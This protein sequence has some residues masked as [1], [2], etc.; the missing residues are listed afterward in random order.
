MAI[1]SLKRLIQRESV[2]RHAEKMARDMHGRWD[3]GIRVSRE[4]IVEKG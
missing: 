1:A 4:I 2:S 3:L